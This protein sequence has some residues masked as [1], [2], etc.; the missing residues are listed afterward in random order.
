M[1][2]D[3]GTGRGTS[4][5]CLGKHV[6]QFLQKPLTDTSTRRKWLGQTHMQ[7]SGRKR[8]EEQRHA[9]DGLHMHGAGGTFLVV[10]KKSNRNYSWHA[11]TVDISEAKFC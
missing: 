5:G 1:L 2:T 9:N 6:H 4:K 7:V 8:A 3:A 11:A 10:R